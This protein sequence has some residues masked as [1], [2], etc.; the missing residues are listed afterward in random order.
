VHDPTPPP[1]TD[2]DRPI[3][4]TC[5]G[6]SIT[7]AQLSVDYL[8]LLG[9][10]QGAPLDR[11]RFAAN[12]D[13]A[14]NLLAR[15]DEAVARPA[16]VITVLI[17]TNDARA[18]LPGYPTEKAVKRKL[19]PS[20]P[21]ASWFQD[22]LSAIVERLRRETDARLGLLSLPVLGQDLDGP[23]LQASDAY[24]RMIAA[25]AADH[26]V[27]YLPL[28]ERQ[29]EHLRQADAAAIPYRELTP[30][31]F[32]GTAL[33][34]LVLRRDLDAIA[35]RRGLLLT[36]DHIHQNSAGARLIAEVID[37]SGLLS[38]APRLQRTPAP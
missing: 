34:R 9:R 8:G 5:L 31:A 26:H 27:A 15:L 20:R 36:T 16:D 1:P 38:P 11:A 25:V 6:D 19:L 12:G 30:A 23:A 18:S 28:H 29:V 14:F 10:H 37:D 24:S 13:F 3:R 2:G 4:L 22:C 33:Q 35:R 32:V 17:G 7:R 21:S